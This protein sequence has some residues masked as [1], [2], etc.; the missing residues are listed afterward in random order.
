M[1]EDKTDERGLVEEWLKKI[2]EAEK[3]YAKYYELVD[4]T[5]D[6]YK[7]SKGSKSGK[8]NIFWSSGRNAEAVSLFQTA[9]ILCRAFQQKC[10]AKP[11]NLPVKCWKTL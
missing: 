5:R 6:F 2:N 9:E 8:Y 3:V 10:R 1:T 11:K 4:E 7:D